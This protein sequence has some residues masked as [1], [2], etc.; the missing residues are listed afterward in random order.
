MVVIIGKF[1]KNY[2]TQ[3]RVII[4]LVKIFYDAPSQVEIP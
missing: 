4:R 3:L 1:S 2:I